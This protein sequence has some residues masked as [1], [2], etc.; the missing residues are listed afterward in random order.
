MSANTLLNHYH[1][2]LS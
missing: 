2:Q 1:G